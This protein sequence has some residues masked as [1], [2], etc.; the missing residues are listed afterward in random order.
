MIA[1]SGQ[2]NSVTLSKHFGSQRERFK[3][4]FATLAFACL[5]QWIPAS[6]AGDC[7]EKPEHEKCPSTINGLREQ[8]AA[9][10]IEK[11]KSI[12]ES[13]S[14]FIAQAAQDIKEAKKL[15]GEAR[16][17]SKKL[18]LSS[19]KLKGKELES[20]KRQYKADL[21]AFSKHVNDYKRHNLEIRNHFGQCK[22][23][24]AAFEKMKEDL[25]L[26]CDQFHM[27]D[28][29][30]PHICLEMGTTVEEA[31]GLQNQA[32]SQAVRLAEAE[33]D[34]QKEEARLQR[35]IA[36]RGA[37]DGIVMAKSQLALQEQKLAEE[38]GRLKEEHR[39]LDV[40]RRALSASGV[41]VAVPSVKARIKKK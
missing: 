24:L 12:I 7:P 3:H 16:Q 18:N 15:Q 29:E 26:H 36:E 14:V 13:S 9:A 23:S 37:V 10:I 19:R 33:L 6:T 38:F 39:Q 11:N 2:E 32:R 22:A 40:E 1:K 21:A 20:A 28:V 34:L 41:K 17:Y 27:P 8:Q 31:R 4:A 30:P 5:I 35:A 25:S